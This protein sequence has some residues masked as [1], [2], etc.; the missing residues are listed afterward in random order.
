MF[1]PKFNISNKLLTHI[2]S[3]EGSKA[4]IDSAP[5]I[6]AWEKTFQ[7]DATIRTVH[8]GTH[9]EGNDL[10]LSQAKMIFENLEEGGF[11]KSAKT[12][13]AQTGVTARDR[14]IQEILNYRKVLEYIDSLKANTQRFT[15]YLDEEI[16]HIHKLTV[17]KILEPER[18]GI[19]RQSRVVVKDAATGE[20]TFTPPN[21]V[22]VPFQIE[23]FLEWLNSFVSKDVHPV[24][25]AGITHYELARIHP[26]VDGNGRVARAMA[27]LVLHREN[28]DI[29]GFFSLEEH[30]DQKPGE[31]YQALQSVTNNNGDLTEWLEYFC[32]GLAQELEA[33]RQKVKELSMDERML[34][35]LGQQIS[36]SERQ[37]KLVEF[38]REHE[39]LFMKDAIKIFPMVSE[40]TILRE[41]KGLI[42]KELVEKIGKTKGAYYVLKLS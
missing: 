24:L 36:L 28:Y 8:Y 15:R 5:L 37:I 29:K 18:A 33:V 7:Q 2:G 34:N 32:F 39:A 12:V 16:K 20:V 6:P 17:D 1:E 26:F 4:V 42:E 23:H 14:D 10:S 30:Y 22:E 21:P 3:I 40:D 11:H 13:A 9:L 35:R 19:Y 31:Y 41:L 38:M 27:T 25:R